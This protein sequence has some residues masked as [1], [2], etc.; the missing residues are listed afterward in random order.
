MYEKIVTNESRINDD[1]I[2]RILR[3]VRPPNMVLPPIKVRDS[4][5]FVFDGFFMTGERKRICV[6]IG[7]DEDFPIVVKRT[8][9]RQAEGYLTGFTLNDASEGLVYVLA[10][11]L[12][13]SWQEQ[14][15]RESK[16]K[17]SEFKTDSYAL[18]KLLAW[19]KRAKKE[20][21]GVK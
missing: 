7:D 19:R 4:K 17:Y 21:S 12:Q 11:E 20:K 5:N 18:K 9:K 3:F 15:L 6:E 13:H 10:H 8:K 2:F 14:N 16:Y 1:V